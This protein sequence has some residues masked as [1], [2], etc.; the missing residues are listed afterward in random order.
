MPTTSDANFSDRLRKV[1]QSANEE[2]LRFNQARIDV[3]HLLLGIVKEG[4]GVAA[5]VLKDL[6][7]DLRSIRLAL[8]RRIEEGLD[9]IATGK[10]PLTKQAQEVMEHAS[11]QAK[12]LKHDYVGTEHLLLALLHHKEGIAYDVL[13]D[14]ELTHA[15]ALE[16]VRSLLGMD[17]PKI[18]DEDLPPG[19]LQLNDVTF[20][21]EPKLTVNRSELFRALSIMMP[22]LSDR[23][24]MVS[25]LNTGKVLTVP[26]GILKLSESTFVVTEGCFDQ[27][28]IGATTLIALLDILSRPTIILSGVRKTETPS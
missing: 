19:V 18:F 23:V 2:A 14:M 20:A 12:M 8:E 15:I 16:Q 3:E 17:V 13:S 11:D 27:P 28:E 24:M 1:L 25:G 22:I 10:L 21:F 7:I 6:D 9:P 5:N 4:T 26:E